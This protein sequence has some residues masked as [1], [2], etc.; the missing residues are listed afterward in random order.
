MK[1]SIF[2]ILTLLF[3][4][5]ALSAKANDTASDVSISKGDY[6]L[7][8]VKWLGNS[9]FC[10]DY[11][12]VIYV[13]PSNIPEGS[14]N[15]DIILLTG[16][17][18]S[19]IDIAALKQI[20]QGYPQVYGPADAIAVLKDAG[21]KLSD[22]QLHII[23]PYDKV[24]EGSYEFE[25]VPAY[26]IV[27]DIN[28]QENGGVGYVVTIPTPRGICN[29]YFTGATNNIPEMESL[30]DKIDVIFLPFGK[31]M[32]LEDVAEAVQISNLINAEIVVPA[33]FSRKFRV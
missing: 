24:N 6:G 4:A 13:N 17:S 19:A 31:D 25:A 3:S 30:K 27:N 15:A 5:F 12:F 22:Y 18:S 10:I 28:P 1:K 11:G 33:F 16:S 23:K 32:V 2:I 7:G 29:L 21:M 26:S 20:S 8:F 9:S 14:K